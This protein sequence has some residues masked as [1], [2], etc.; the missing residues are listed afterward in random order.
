MCDLYFI[1]IESSFSVY[2]LLLPN[3]IIHAAAVVIKI[4]RGYTYCFI[5]LLFCE[6]IY[7]KYFSHISKLK[8]SSII[9]TPPYCNTE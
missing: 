2:F 3:I 9:L 7:F 6:I 4:E 8:F 1:S 5:S